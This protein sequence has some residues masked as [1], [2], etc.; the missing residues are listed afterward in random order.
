MRIAQLSSLIFCHIS[1]AD[2]FILFWERKVR[3]NQLPKLNVSNVELLT[4]SACQTAVGNN[5]GLS[6]SALSAGVKTVLASLWSVSDAGTALLMMKF[7]SNYVDA[8][9]KSAEV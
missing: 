6:G 2:S 1:A 5:L 8:S 9:S 7:Y 4:L 3:T